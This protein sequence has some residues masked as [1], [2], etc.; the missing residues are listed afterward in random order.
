VMLLERTAKR[1]NEAGPH[2]L[3]A[4]LTASQVGW[5]DGNSEEMMAWR[6]GLASRV[7]HRSIEDGSI[8]PSIH[9]FHGRGP[10]PVRWAV[11][12]GPARNHVAAFALPSLAVHVVTLTHI[13]RTALFCPR[14]VI[15]LIYLHNGVES[16]LRNNISLPLFACNPSSHFSHF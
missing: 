4:P 1:G 15:K 8:Y 10:R 3:A 11:R 6:A 5:R 14:L 2:E 16:L 12:S 13:T 7:A 9:G